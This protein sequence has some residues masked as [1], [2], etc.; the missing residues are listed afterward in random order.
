M[1]HQALR[2]RDVTI[3]CVKK[4]SD[5]F[6]VMLDAVQNHS[7]RVIVVDELRDSRE[8]DA[9]KTIANQGV[10]LLARVHATNLTQLAHNPTLTPLIGSVKSA[11]TGDQH[12]R[13]TYRQSKYR[14]FLDGAYPV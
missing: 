2:T 10:V 4:S 7:A 14:E 3:L 9:A 8:V 6:R 11:L 1:P 5:L 12:M 13:E